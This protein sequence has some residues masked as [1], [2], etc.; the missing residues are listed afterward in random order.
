MSVYKITELNIYSKSIFSIICDICDKKKEAEMRICASS[1]VLLLVIFAFLV[2]TN[3]GHSTQRPSSREDDSN[4]F[5]D[6]ATSFLQE[7][8]ANQNGGGGGG[9]GGAGGMAGIASLIGSFIQPEAKSNGDG[10]AAGFGGAAQILSG[11]GSLLANANGGGG[12][13]GGG[14]DPSIIGN[15]IEMFTANNNGASNND[16]NRKRRSSVDDN[17]VEESAGGGGIGLDTI[18]NVVSAFSGA[19]ATNNKRGG[20]GGGGQEDG[21]M[22]LLPM[23]MQ[24][25]NSFAGPEGERMQEK[26]KEHAWVLPPF[27]EKIHVMWDHF[28]NSELAEALWKKSGVY[29]IFKV[30]SPSH[31][32]LN[33]YNIYSFI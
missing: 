8:L 26:H 5:L 2:S 14:F 29:S 10:G 4:P 17:N 27:L 3:S 12:G 18:L 23:V 25:V 21:L 1:S 15:V 11:L 30:R 13:G 33:L 31:A 6:L 7:T 24:A 19:S 16:K 22:S 32:P 20:G 28:S 9:G